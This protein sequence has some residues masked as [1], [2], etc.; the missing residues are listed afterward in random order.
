MRWSDGEPFTADD[1]VYWYE[2]EVK[3]F[4]VPPPRMLRS[5]A[6]LGWVEK[7]DD[8]CVRFCFAQPN[9]LFPDLNSR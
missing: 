8:Y 7:V 1:L 9:P 6:G 2:N 5:G 3:Y 4:K